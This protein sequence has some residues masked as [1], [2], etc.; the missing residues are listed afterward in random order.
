ML[1]A[2]VGTM[3]ATTQ[4]VDLSALPA[5]SES[6]TWT[7]NAETSS[8]VF[9]WSASWSNSTELF[10]A[11][12]YS[13]YAS[14]NYII[15]AGTSDR[16][17]IIIK[18]TNG[19]EQTT[20]SASCGAKSLSW[21][22]IGVDPAN[23]PYIQS[24]R[25]SGAQTASGDIIVSRIFLADTPMRIVN[26]EKALTATGSTFPTVTYK[27]FHVNKVPDLAFEINSFA[28][29]DGYDDF[30]I[31]IAVPT[32]VGDWLLANVAEPYA[33]SGW[34][35]TIGTGTS[36]RVKL[37]EEHEGTTSLV[38]QAGN[39]DGARDIILKD[40]YFYKT[41]GEVKSSI[42]ASL[43]GENVVVEEATAAGAKAFELS[44]V[45]VTG[46]KKLEISFASPTVGTWIVNCDGSEE[47]IPEGTSKYTVDVSGKTTI[48]N[49]TL[50]VGAGTFPRVNNFDK[51]CLT[52]TEA[53]VMNAH[54]NDAIFSFADA[55]N[56]DTD[57]KRFEAEKTGG[58]TFTTPVDLSDYLYLIITTPEGANNGSW[59]VTL[60]DKNDKSIG[61]G[62]YKWEES[63]TRGGCMY[64]DTWNHNNVVCVNLAYLEEKGMDIS[65]ISSLK[66]S[67]EWGVQTSLAINNVILT[68]YANSEFVCTGGTDQWHQYSTGQSTR[69]IHE[70]TDIGKFGT[71]CLP[72]K[73]IASGAFIYSIASGNASGI[74]LE[75]VDGIMEAGKAYFYEATD[76]VGKDGKYNVQFFRADWGADVATPVSAAANK[77]LAGTFT[78]TTAPMGEKYMV[79]SS[80]NL[81]TVDSAVSIAAN[82]AWIDLNYVPAGGG[83]AKTFL[84]FGDE[85]PN[86][87]D[88][89]SV[90]IE[91]VLNGKFYDLQGREVENPTK[92]IYIVNGKKVVIK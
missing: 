79:L 3:L 63:E 68:N 60:T 56:F 57:T 85:E 8:G 71:I 17:R 53:V 58:W 83:A 22:V 32:T 76:A 28:I 27:K 19:T 44:N 34:W 69:T 64:L 42:L 11:G 16:F 80:N 31:D 87:T 26:R 9:A 25:L 90:E 61:G 75:R 1:I 62:D 54:A 52:Y 59:K 4:E 88:I 91:E 14:L 48:S 12:D 21:S 10:G 70:A 67:P 45:D 74:N 78:D 33:H 37:G 81:Y 43:G 89:N 2:Q 50:S 77:G 47:N 20:Y 24:I 49:I 92:G 13:A 39:P 55:A 30:Y 35:E 5:T 36:G 29:P 82:K 6:T 46:Y 18:Y 86:A 73:A 51:V 7:W 84:S 38:L 41:E 23:L 65:Q 15:S 72:Y 66:F 40:A